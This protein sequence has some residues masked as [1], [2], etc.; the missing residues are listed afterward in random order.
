MIR[1]KERGNDNSWAYASLHG[2][3]EYGDL[4]GP[5]NKDIGKALLDLALNSEGRRAYRRMGVGA[6][7]FITARKLK[8]AEYAGAVRCLVIIKVS[9]TSLGS[10]VIS[11]DI[12][13]QSLKNL[14]DELM[15]TEKIMRYVKLSWGQERS[16]GYLME[17]TES[18]IGRQAFPLINI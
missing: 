17:K 16:L 10:R 8:V 11:K 9:D 3:L 5:K 2:F 1:E 4:E 6:T 13:E 15:E 7:A 14:I 12:V 18:A